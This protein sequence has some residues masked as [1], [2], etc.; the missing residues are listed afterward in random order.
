MNRYINFD[1]IGDSILTLF[2]MSTNEGWVEIMNY[3]VD[4]AGVGM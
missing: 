2:I 3:A 1:N 4:S